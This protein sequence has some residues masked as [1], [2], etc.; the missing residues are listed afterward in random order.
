MFE[1]VAK[2]TKVLLYF[3][4]LFLLLFPHSLLPLSLHPSP[5]SPF[6]ILFLFHSLLPL[7]LFPTPPPFSPPPFPPPSFSTTSFSTPPV[8]SPLF[9]CLLPLLL[10]LL[11]FSALLFHS[12][13]L[14]QHVFCF[15][16]KSFSALLMIEF[17][18]KQNLP[19]WG[20]HQGTW[21]S[22]GRWNISSWRGACD[23]G[24]VNNSD[25]S[26]MFHLGWT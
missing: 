21:C 4:H 7:Y 23:A 11:S 10:F 24:E 6:L 8:A 3:L 9:S 16:L 2:L 1:I 25:A 15:T 20:S 18:P 22:K 14:F 13:S 5:S 12:H 26:G 17:P 19:S